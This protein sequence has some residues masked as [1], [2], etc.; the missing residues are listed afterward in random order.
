[1]P[2]LIAVATEGRELI[3][4][5]PRR[6]DAKTRQPVRRI[7][8]A[9]ARFY[10][11][12]DGAELAEVVDRAQAAVHDA[13]VDTQRNG[14]GPVSGG[15][16]SAELIAALQDDT[17]QEVIPTGFADLDAVLDGYARGE[18]TVVCGRPGHGKTMMGVSAIKATAVAGGLATFVFSL[19]M[20]RKKLFQRLLASTPA[21]GV[22]LAKLKKTMP[23]DQRD[24]A[25]L[26]RAHAKIEEANL[27][28]DD[29]SHQTV[30]TIRTTLRRHIQQHGQLDVVVIDYLG[31][32]TAVRP[33]ERK[34]LELGE[35]SRALKVLAGELDV[36][37]VLLHQLN[38]KSTER[39]DRKPQL[40]DLHNSGAIEQDAYAVVAVQNYVVDDP[41]TD[42]MGE[43]D[44]HVLKN[45][46]GP[47]S[48]ITAAFQARFGRIVDMAKEEPT[49]P[50]PGRANLSIVDR[51]DGPMP[52][53]P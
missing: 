44:L 45:R 50:P 21:H 7:D 28:I 47:T 32:L 37:I 41:D 36:A 1:M 8:V 18:I 49:P 40:S 53:V 11:G 16:A 4:R 22:E 42:R 5:R 19:E 43:A 12:S 15:H 46:Q 17:E 9:D 38:R 23:L 51:V 13:T 24:W 27:W 3:G 31:L 2:D 30:S 6:C 33:A 10:H 52:T 35:M 29:S 25:E 39:V 26:E 48:T 14:D 34:D 20:S